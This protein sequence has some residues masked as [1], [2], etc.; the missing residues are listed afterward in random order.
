[1]TLREDRPKVLIIGAGFG[2]LYA[3]RSLENKPVEV[4]V[5]DRNNFHTFTPLLYQVA[6]CGLEPEEIAYPVRG[7]FRETPNLH[8]MLGEV[9]SI[10]AAAKTV[11][12]KTNG[13]TRDE[14]YDYLILAAGSITNYMNVDSA[15]QHGFGLKTLE[16][17]VDLRNHILRLFERAAWTD[18]T[19][20]RE[21]LTTLVVI[22]GGPTGLETAGALQEL[23]Q[24]VLRKE[25]DFL[26][27]L[28]PRVILVEAVDRL[29][30][31]FPEDLQTA[32]LEQ[33][34]SL[35]IE[36]I[37]NT[38]VSDVAQDHITLN[39]GH[40]IQTHTLVWSAGVSASPLAR[41]L[42]VE[43]KRNG[44]VPVLQTLEVEGL[45]DIYAVGDMAYLENPNGH[46]YPM[47]IPAAKQQ[48]ILAA[49][50]ILRR[51]AGQSEQPFHYIDRGIMATIG[52]NR[53]VAHVYNRVSLRGFSAWVAWLGLHLVALMGFR[54]RINVLTNWGWNYLTYDRSVRIIL[55]HGER[56]D[57]EAGTSISAPNETR[58]DEAVAESG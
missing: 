18:D 45:R 25:Y 16:E 24:K 39:D 46:P 55:G 57:S 41:L 37:L 42:G 48:G 6:S 29:L 40:T 7:I 52:R 58:L 1:M 2:G 13:H 11:S 50:N 9:L 21:A 20:L 8:F 4:L 22:G 31:P 43:L 26:K 28:Q 23:I 3:A 47:M 36:V 14:S 15:A 54:N 5:I 56:E 32:A 19:K 35:G 27:T 44:R 12:V 34:R 10:D 33:A 51:E 17:A 38:A 53:A 30:V 49:K